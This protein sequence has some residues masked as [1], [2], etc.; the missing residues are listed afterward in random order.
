MTRTIVGIGCVLSGLMFGPSAGAWNEAGHHIV[1]AMA[2]EELP[3]AVKSKAA[4][5]LKEHPDFKKWKKDF[6]GNVPGLDLDKYV[7]LRASVWPDVIR[8]SSLPE[9]IRHPNWHFVDY[10][11]LPPDFPAKPRPAPKDD[12]IFG[13]QECEDALT[14]TSALMVDQARAL[15]FLIHLVGDIHQPLHCATL[16]NGTFDDADGDRGG[17]ELFVRTETEGNHSTNK[18]HAYWDGLLGH[19]ESLRTNLNLAAS[20]AQ[21]FP[22]SAL[23]ELNTART[24]RKWSLESRRLSVDAAYKDLDLSSDS[25]QDAKLLTDQYKSRARSAAEKRVA[26]AAHRL[27]D[28]LKLVLSTP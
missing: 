20:L 12:V 16:F 8:H 2:Y 24:L 28:R 11:L 7:F 14:D 17:N 25:P 6:P 19:S 18:L 23:P 4:A 27:A 3:D 21:K 10:P 13:I 9:S 1:A 22:R 5:L 15:S 26:L